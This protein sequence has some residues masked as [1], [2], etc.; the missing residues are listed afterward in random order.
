M[1]N[2]EYEA[3]C[4]MYDI[5]VEVDRICKKNN[6]KYTLYGGTLIGAIR[7]DGFIPWDDDIDIAFLRDDYEKFLK[8]CEK[9]LN[10]EYHVV[11]A[12]NEEDNP[13]LFHKI[14]IKNTIYVED[15]SKDSST[16]QEI[17]IDLFPIDN[18]PQNYFVAYIQNLKASFYERV[19]AIKCKHNF[20]KN[21][22]LVKRILN[23]LLLVFSSL[24]RKNSLIKKIKKLAVKY[25]NKETEYVFCAYAGIGFKERMK[26]E[27]YSNYILHQFENDKFYILKGYDEYLKYA[28]G[29]YMEL[30]PIEERTSRHK[31]IEIDLG[32]YKI[33]N[34]IKE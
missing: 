21:K 20:S 7:H 13:N 22:N 23:F 29:D 15:I 34:Y 24:Y 3:K 31:V 2:K 5:L 11:N 32:D 33:Q 9:D 16:N 28:Y 10:K 19:L 25:N 12:E 6:I 27:C 30:P 14:K 1:S 8:C 4:C 17:F 26:K 18:S